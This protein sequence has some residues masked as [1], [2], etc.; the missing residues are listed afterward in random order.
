MLSSAPCSA[1]LAGSPWPAFRHDSLHTGRA[2]L[3]APPS[4]TLAWSRQVGAGTSSP[5]L[6]TDA[7]YVLANGNLVAMS[8]NGNQLWSYACAGNRSSPAVSTSGVVY[9]A[10]TD[11]YLYAVNANGTLKWR[12]SI[13]AASTSSPTIGADGSIYVGTSGGKLYAFTS[14][15]ASKF[16]YAAGGAISSSPAIASDGTIYF[17]CD[18]GCLYALNS[19]GTLKWKFTTSPLGAIQSSPA[20]GS[21]GTI[22]FGASSGFIFA[23][24][25]NGTQRWRYASGVSTSSPAIASDGTIYVGSQDNSL[26]ALSKVGAF[27]WKYTARGQINS[28]PAIDSNGIICFGSDDGSIYAVNPDGTKLWEY[29]TGSLVASSP[30]IG[31]QHS[32]YVLTWA[33]S[34]LRLGSDTTPPETPAVIDD[35]AYSTFPTT[36]HAS[37]SSA[38]PESGIARYEYA[39]GTTAGGEELLPFTDAGAAT[40]V[41]AAGLA[42]TNGA[43][44]F[45]SVRATNGVGLVSYVGVSDGILVDF[46]PPAVP[47]VIDDGRYT[48]SA[49]TLHFVYGSGDTESGISYYE[50]S[51]GTAAGASDVLGWRN[52]GLVREQTLTVTLTHGATYYANVRAHNCAGLTSEGSSNGILVDLTAPP[53]PTVEIISASASSVHLKITA[54]DPES[55]IA[56][57]QYAILTSSDTTNAAWTD[58]AVGVEVT[59][60]GIGS[61]QVYVAGRAKNG[62]NLWSTPTVVSST[63]DTT[64]PTTPIVTD[65]GDY[66]SDSTSLHA[67]WV[68]QDPQSGVASYSYSIGTSA[69]A[70]DVLAWTPTTATSANVTGLSLATGVRYYFNVKAVNAV[71]LW[72][73]VGSSDGIEYRTQTSV[74][75]KFRRDL[76]NAGTSSITGCL[77]G[78]VEW[79]A[80]TTGY[81]ESS[82][83]FAGDGGVYIGSGDGRVYAI[84][85]SGSIRWTYQTGG[86]VDSSPAI[87]PGGEIYVGSCDHYLYCLSP[88]GALNWRYA[89][90]NMIWSSPAV[91]SDGT[92]HFGGQDGCIYAL[93][94][95]GALKWRYNAGAAVWSSPAIASDGTVY[96]ACGNGKLYA[97]TSAGALKWSYAS[98]TAA[99][100]SPAIGTNGV[101]Y[102]GSGDGY[103]YAINPNGTLRWRSYTGSLVDSSA[104]I[105]AD[106]T[107]Y[108]GTGG[109]GLAGTLRAYTS[110]GVQLW[111]VSLT[112][113][114]RSSPAL[115]GSGNLY[116]GTADGVVHALRSDG[117]P[118]WTARAGDSV[119]G[120]P[121]IGPNGQV[122]VG[123][124]DGAVYCFRDYANDATPP[125]TPVVTPAQAFLPK[126][127]PLVCHWSA[128]DPE[129]GVASY[130]YCVGT[131]PGA[132][133]IANWANA[134][135]ATSCSR[136]DLPMTVGQSL[137]LSV[138]AKNHSGLE[139]AVGTSTAIVIVANDQDNLIGQ[140]RKRPDGT[141]VYLPGKTVTAV[142]SDCVFVE[143]PD[144]TAGI[145]CDVSS[146]DL[147]A[148]AVVDALGKITFRN[149]EP[150]LTEAT[151]SRLNIAAGP[152]TPYAVSLRSIA[153][154]AGASGSA[155]AGLIGLKVR[156]SGRVTKVGAYYFVLS[157]GTDVTSPRGVKGIEVRAGAGDIPLPNA[158]V[159]IT[160]IVSRDIVNGV[161]T[162]ILRATAPPSLTILQ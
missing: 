143:E 134:G 159:S 58:C 75:P 24:N 34:L 160:A 123:S 78:R 151:L 111:Q 66:T 72:S 82:A 113:G 44:Y 136:S 43:R 95:N 109:A 155:S 116:F 61:G 106:G 21:D 18:D 6:G 79:R 67:T 25:P 37:W 63:V 99:D 83:A 141:R 97:L 20:I 142:Y 137:Y 33:G 17:G 150:V 13:G 5:A 62:V 128:T 32:I 28:S 77:S 65:D 50:Y 152:L 53:A 51:I 41:T 94:A 56:Q 16:T 26:Y 81:V 98:G 148:G 27:R 59:A 54:A 11:G 156:V 102:F 133:N 74:W 104:A 110:D 39:I 76:A 14:E 127:A 112:G 101:V 49:T 131:T 29:P 69:G 161:P 118:I 93:N 107:V 100:S 125:T 85:P 22:H 92:I 121:A 162:T 138:K 55:G 119:L 157:D 40:Q 89:T 31:E 60:A 144:R 47:V 154:S 108:V 96:Y 129:S 23:V 36:L 88:G 114:V 52:A 9:V 70:T 86:P 4:P 103:F 132:S 48:G 15:G 30:A 90:G 149:G 84:N 73:A 7:I 130:S 64:P 10:S 57:G 3:P 68:A 1:Q 139:S 124:D 80:Q 91:A 120:S 117:G 153:N 135:A 38:D 158:Y 122:V 12:K 140:A 126:G 42:L 115:D 71:G 87:G 45:F 105:G 35:G 8:P 19:T 146:S 145:R 46:T 147:T 2:A